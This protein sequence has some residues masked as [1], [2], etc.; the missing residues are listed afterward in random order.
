MGETLRKIDPA[1]GPAIQAELM[2]DQQAL[3]NPA[4]LET[5]SRMNQRAGEVPADDICDRERH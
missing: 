1:D 2:S 5:T 3:N 4:V